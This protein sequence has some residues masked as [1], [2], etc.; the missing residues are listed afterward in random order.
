MSCPICENPNP[1]YFIKNSR[2]IVACNGCI[3]PELRSLFYG[4]NEGG[5]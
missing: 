1:D 4:K 2:E 3:S 5:K